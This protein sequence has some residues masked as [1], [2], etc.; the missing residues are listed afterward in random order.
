MSKEN[1]EASPRAEA[2]KLLKARLSEEGMKAGELL[3]SER[4]LAEEFG[5][6]RRAVQWA[7]NTLEEQKYIHK[8]G[9][10]TRAK[11][12]P[13]QKV[14][15]IFAD[16]FLL[17]KTTSYSNL[18][19]SGRASGWGR[20][21]SFGIYDELSRDNKNILQ[22]SDDNYEHL[23]QAFTSIRIR[24]LFI[25]SVGWRIQTLENHLIQVAEELDFPLV[26]GTNYQKYRQFDRVDSDQEEGAFLLT[27]YLLERGSRR[28]VLFFDHSERLYW[29]EDRR[30]G[31]ERA[32][33]EAELEPVPPIFVDIELDLRG[34]S[35]QRVNA[36][37]KLFAGFLGSYI[38][39]DN[40]VDAIMAATD[41]DVPVVG[42]AC[43]I[44]GKKPGT[45]ILLAGYDNFWNEGEEFRVI[46][47]KPVATIDKRNY[48]VG[49]KC[50]KLML[51]RCNGEL[52]AAP[53]LRKVSPKLV[54]V[55]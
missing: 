53:Q 31:Y 14:L 4:S 40:P 30:Q 16:T 37:A 32:M 20:Q 11:S 6:G 7:L 19:R 49:Q 23:K 54:V 27:K 3:P 45:D 34:A 48:L 44:L 42:M 2:L 17:P 38:L 5:T 50:V 24:G 29:M 13:P 33:Q 25:P 35:A 22:I 36:R 10:R 8:I 15:P 46:Q 18:L 26:C 39:G 55:E 41:G 12:E 52:P 47:T 1:L 51:Q 28:P 21:I 9:P 43:E